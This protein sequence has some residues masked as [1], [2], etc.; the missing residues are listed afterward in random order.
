MSIFLTQ[1][2]I[3]LG[4]FLVLRLIIFY[5][6]SNT[7]TLLLAFAIFFSWYSLLVNFLN[8]TGAIL[9]FPFLIRTGLLAGYFDTTLLFIYVRNSFYPGITWKKTDWLLLLP[10]LFYLIDMFPFFISSP[11][12]KIAVFT[13]N[14]SD[15]SAYLRAKE[16]WI[17]ISGFHFTFQYL[18]GLTLNALQIV[19]I[20]RNKDA[21]KNIGNS[22][23]NPVFWFLLVITL[24]YLPLSVP[25]VFG[26]LMHATWLTV[27]YIN[28]SIAITLITTTLYLFFYPRILL[29]FG[30]RPALKDIVGE[31]V[32]SKHP[33]LPKAE[34]EERTANLSRGYMKREESLVLISKLDQF[35]L[36]KKPFLDNEYSIHN[37]SADLG[38]PV[39]QLSPLI[40]QHYKDNFSSWINKYRVDHFIS[41]WEN[42]TNQELTLDALSKQSGF[43]NRRTFINAFKKARNTTPSLYLKNN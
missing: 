30:P 20:I 27:G 28:T 26:L 8:E 2:G 25:G 39:Y 3:A 41:L 24:C 7:N 34:P 38:V 40:N 18:W 43:S 16:G 14:L 21:R 22:N 36:E 4:F 29:G 42:K 1:L 19:M 23:N 17:A 12:N 32:T 33:E 10:A 6:K 15:P 35:M 9:Q 37:L 5:R 11:E 13:S 31:T